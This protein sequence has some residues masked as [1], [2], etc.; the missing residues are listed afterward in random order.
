MPNITLAELLQLPAS[1]QLDG[2]IAELRGE[3]TNWDT[4]YPL[5]LHGTEIPET[6]W[7]AVPWPC[8]QDIN[9]AWPLLAELLTAGQGVSFSVAV[10]GGLHVHSWTVRNNYGATA[11]TLAAAPLAIVRAWATWKLGGEG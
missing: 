7:W 11:P 5:V 10:D 9:F 3:Q 8:S 6:A 4:G 1:R 2:H